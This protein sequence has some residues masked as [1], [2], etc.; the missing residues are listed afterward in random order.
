M[1]EGGASSDKGRPQLMGRTFQREKG[2]EE[3]ALWRVGQ[4]SQ[5]L[6]ARL[7]LRWGEAAV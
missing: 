2:G 4:H 5:D 1:F 7:G 3:R 6:E